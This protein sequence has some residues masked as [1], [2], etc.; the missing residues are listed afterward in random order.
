MR[1]GTLYRKIKDGERGS[2][3]KKSVDETEGSESRGESRDSI[4]VIKHSVKA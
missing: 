2:N 3:G 1:A 4:T